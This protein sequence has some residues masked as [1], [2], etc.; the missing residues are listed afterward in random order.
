MST[1]KNFRYLQNTHSLLNLIRAQAP[2]CGLKYD[3]SSTYLISA[4][5]DGLMKIWS[6]WSPK[7]EVGYPLLRHSLRGHT[8]PVKTFDI[9]L[10]NHLLVSIDT[11]C[12]LVVWCLRTG[13]PLV[14][15]RG[16]ERN[17]CASGLRKR[18]GWVIV[19]TE[20]LGLHFIR[21]THNIYP[22]RV[23][24]SN[25]FVDNCCNVHLHRAYNFSLQGQETGN[26][27]KALSLQISPGGQ[28]IAVGCS[29]Q[30]IRFFSFG[31]G[32]CPVIDGRASTLE[33]RSNILAFSNSGLQLA[34][35][36]KEDGGCWLWGLKGGI[37][38]GSKLC[39]KKRPK[40][41]PSS[42]AW[43]YNDAYLFVGLATGFIFVFKGETGVCITSRRS[44]ED[45]VNAIAVSPHCEEI[46]ATGGCD[47]RFYIFQLNKSDLESEP[48]I[49]CCYRLP[50][51]Q[52]DSNLGMSWLQ[53][54]NSPDGE[55]LGGT[56]VALPPTPPP[57]IIEPEMLADAH[58]E[59]LVT[60]F[61]RP[62]PSQAI[63]CCVALPIAQGVGFI[64]GSAGG[65]V[66]IFTPM[67]KERPSWEP[68]PYEEQFFHWELD[69]AIIR[70]VEHQNSKVASVLGSE[71]RNHRPP[72]TQDSNSPQENTTNNNG[73][74]EL[75]N[76]YRPPKNVL[77]EVVHRRS[78][79][80][81]SRLP[82]GYLVH[83]NGMPYSAPRQ[84][85]QVP[86]RVEEGNPTT[87][88][89]DGLQDEV[90]DDI[91]FVP[92]VSC[93]YVYPPPHPSNTAT[94]LAKKSHVEYFLQKQADEKKVNCEAPPPTQTLSILGEVD[95]FSQVGVVGTNGNR[96]AHELVSGTV[97]PSGE[98][99][100]L[101]VDDERTA[102]S[103]SSDD[104]PDWSDGMNEEF[105]W[106]P[107]VRSR[108][109][110]NRRGQP[111]STEQPTITTTIE[112]VSPSSE[113]SIDEDSN[114]V[115]RSER[116]RQRRRQERLNTNSV[117][118]RLDVPHPMSRFRTSRRLRLRSRLRNF[119]STRN[120]DFMFQRVLR[121]RAGS[122]SLS[123][124]MPNFQQ[125]PSTR[126]NVSR[127]DRQEDLRQRLIRSL[128]F[129]VMNNATYP[130]EFPPSDGFS[131][132]YEEGVTA[133]REAITW[134]GPD[135]DWLSATKPSAAPYVPQVGDRVLYIMRGHR[136]Y[137]QKAWQN[138]QVP[139]IDA[140]EMSDN[141]LHSETL[142]LPWDQCPALHGYVCCQVADMAI[143]FMR[144]TRIPNNRRGLAARASPHRPYRHN[145]GHAAY[146]RFSRSS[147]S[148][149]DIENSS[150][151]VEAELDSFVRLVSLRLT[152]EEYQPYS[153]LGASEN[154]PPPSQSLL[155][156]EIYIRYH[157]VVGVLDFL[158]LRD[159]FDEAVNRSW[160]AGDVFICPVEAVWW[161]GRV[162]R[163]FSVH[164]A[165]NP[166]ASNRV[167]LADP[168]LGVRVRWLENYETGA[169]NE[170]LVP[171]SL[172]NCPGVESLE[173]NFD[174]DVAITF[175]DFL[176]PW[177]MHPWTSRLPVSD[178]STTN[179]S[180]VFMHSSEIS[181]TAD[182]LKRLYGSGGS[183]HLFRPEMESSS[184][185][186]HEHPVS[187]S[188]IISH[189]EKIIDKLME[190]EAS[191]AFCT[192]V[193][194]SL[195]P[196]YI[197][198]NPY[199]VDLLFVRNRLDASFYRQS[200]AIR[201]DLE[202]IAK[203]AVRYN[204]PDSLIVRQAQLIT[205]LALKPLSNPA[206]NID[207]LMTDYIEAVHLDH[208]LD[209]SI[210]LSHTAPPVNEVED[211]V[212]VVVAEEE[213]IGNTI[214]EVQPEATNPPTQSPRASSS[215][216]PMAIA[217]S[218][219]VV[220]PRYPLR[221]L[222]SPPPP[223]PI[224]EPTRPDVGVNNVEDGMDWRKECRKVLRELQHHQ[225][226][227][228]FR[229]PVNVGEYVTYLDVVE[230]P[231]DLSTVGRRLLRS[232]TRNSVQPYT[233]AQQFIDDLRLIVHNSRLF[234]RE[235]DTQVY[236][237]TIWLSK[238]ISK[239]AIKR[240]SEFLDGALGSTAAPTNGGISRFH[241]PRRNLRSNSRILRN[242]NEDNVVS[243]ENAE[244][245][246]L[247]GAEVEVA[248]D[249]DGA[250]VRT[251]RGRVCRGRPKRLCS[252][253][254]N[255][256]T[257]PV[258]STNASSTGTRSTR[259]GRRGPRRRGPG[260]PRLSNG[261]AV[262]KCRSRS[263]RR[264]EE[265]DNESDG[266]AP[267]PPKRRSRRRAAAASRHYYEDSD[268][269]EN[270]ENADDS[271]NANDVEWDDDDDEVE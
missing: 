28:R 140:V 39:F 259:R 185:S 91:Q 19:A 187:F 142:P 129:A 106:N 131:Y 5:S 56:T 221:T 51:T 248:S 46:F 204:E 148:S 159:V 168:W 211:D 77:H 257:S 6:L 261:S 155:P 62:K 4:S 114:A 18:E 111:G 37:W 190:L 166:S 172:S 162:L 145:N 249:D 15:F 234:N 108:R 109:N 138:G 22:D 156:E 207:D 271:D 63:T 135:I 102:W 80:P 267:T 171:P 132:Q 82:P 10:D 153:A 165:T 158:V 90:V 43:S 134:R 194:L 67:E 161:R 256:S 57:T 104:D 87:M 2:V 176:C 58:I 167:S 41:R 107:A 65:L 220:E 115:R 64:V 116:Q 27:C 202:H 3:R 52:P 113:E 216:E 33:A 195:F 141:I 203:N 181:I 260:R 60:F 200:Q 188:Q 16:Y 79:V 179:I 34:T 238:W 139:A 120:R 164:A 92:T 212:V 38:I 152:L 169:A 72:A 186:D 240:L 269:A 54:N 160:G 9:S 85:A 237:D 23:T 225:R 128:D 74:S 226:S 154:T 244:N 21:Y 232:Q 53:T 7:P 258:P 252:N 93:Q 254:N 122:L 14:S 150:V 123:H 71:P 78:G 174:G 89:F 26:K 149:L 144:I 222:T 95:T 50:A 193:D 206:Y 214:E 209:S 262:G 48:T 236:A 223:P 205:S 117:E 151:N 112:V 219:S 32:G 264:E 8:S 105:T 245:G 208:E 215:T 133:D 69:E 49:L 29:D 124:S 36:S 24:G 163:D 243:P 45:E 66:S 191:R 70:K 75:D 198:V 101:T 250:T 127:Y 40:K 130:L 84:I 213:E 17:G 147:P 1:T 229:S 246:N 31:E 218:E 61:P 44:H 96:G 173:G 100:M 175:S 192:Y 20:G 197:T 146:S 103:D 182:R 266:E 98:I 239:V 157:D 230:N 12:T 125:M 227:S 68:P 201:F 263:R 253:N 242:Y 143:H 137:L 83:M 178:F 73:N 177:D 233:N 94:N 86:G 270:H 217:V 180:S 59:Q 35:G 81:F 224:A 247:P 99:S 255:T 11:S 13:Q 210:A 183:R 118:N 55:A 76:H 189:T 196:N 265:V 110:R 251:L 184:T 30:S 136:E 268:D 199:M 241:L 235:P 231:M 170:P 228:F 88:N 47:G 119:P 121:R 42:I 97:V 25:R 126:S